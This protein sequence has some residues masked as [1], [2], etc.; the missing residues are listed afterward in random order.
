MLLSLRILRR[1]SVFVNEQLKRGVCF[2]VMSYTNETI[3]DRN[4]FRNS[5]REKRVTSVNVAEAV[6]ATSQMQI[7][8][9]ASV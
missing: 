2:T 7:P 3:F 1:I 5:L 9:K 4:F 6:M 8:A